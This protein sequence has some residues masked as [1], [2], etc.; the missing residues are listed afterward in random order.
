MTNKWSVVFRGGVTATKRQLPEHSAKR[1]DAAQEWDL[2]EW[3]VTK[4]GSPI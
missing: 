3:N 4:D 2:V 1:V